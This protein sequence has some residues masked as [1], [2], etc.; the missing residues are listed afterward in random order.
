MASVPFVLHREPQ[1]LHSTGF[2][3]GPFRQRGVPIAT[4]RYHENSKTVYVPTKNKRMHSASVLGGLLFEDWKC[5]CVYKMMR[6]AQQFKS[7]EMR[8][9]M[10]VIISKVFEWKVER[11]IVSV[12]STIIILM[13]T[14][15]YLKSTI[16]FNIY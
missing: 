6:S 10:S 1:A 12:Y 15:D 14:P 11:A 16:T 8:H 9:F 13:S 4:F 2:S 5:F 7:N 3:G